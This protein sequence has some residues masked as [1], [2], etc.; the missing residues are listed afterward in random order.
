MTLS[1]LV[2]VRTMISPNKISEIRSMGSRT[3]RDDINPVLTM[4]APPR[5]PRRGPRQAEGP[6]SDYQSN[7]RNGQQGNR[8]AALGAA[9]GHERDDT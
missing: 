6:A 8:L 3:E 2:L 4:S 1:V 9:T 5:S 7:T